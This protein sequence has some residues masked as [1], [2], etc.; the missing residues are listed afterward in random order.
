[1]NLGLRCLAL[2][3]QEMARGVHAAPYGQ[4]NTSVDVRMYLAPCVRDLN[5]DGAVEETERLG[6]RVGNWCAAFASW[7]MRESLLPGEVAPHLYRAGVVEIVDDAQ[8]RGLWH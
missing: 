7:C 8:A 6:L 5:R 4:P 1:M 3:R 2:A